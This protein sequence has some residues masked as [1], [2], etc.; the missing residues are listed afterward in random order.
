MALVYEKMIKGF[1]A[2]FIDGNTAAELAYQPQFLSNNHAHGRKVLSSI[3]DELLNCNSFYISVAFITLSGIE[4]LL[5]TF[6]E[7]EKKGVPGKILTTDYLTFSQP[8]ALRKLKELS[9]ID[10]RMYCTG[11]DNDGFHTKGYIFQDVDVYRIIIGSSNMTSAAL[12]INKEW[13]T[14]IVSTEKGA[15]TVQILQEFETLWKSN[16][17]KPY[18]DFIGS[19]ETK[20]N[21]I[22]EQRKRSAQEEKFSVDQFTLEPN[23]MQV[24]F[25]KNLHGMVEDGA[26]KALLISA[27]GE[28]VIIVIPHGSAVNTRA[29]AA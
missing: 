10:L 5:Q 23:S 9:N 18:A 8:K 28:R 22:K 29:S 11:G 20:Y 19:Y 12:T 21:A 15:F 13:N 2:A 1:E 25:I 16:K 7:L 24:E 3:E 26:K 17:T 14:K 4:P 27:T 6:K